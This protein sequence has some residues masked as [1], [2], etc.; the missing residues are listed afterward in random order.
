M[1]VELAFRLSAEKLFNV[2]V[3]ISPS[4]VVN[5]VAAHK[6]WNSQAFTPVHPVLTNIQDF[7]HFVCDDSDFEKLDYEPREKNETFL[8]SGY[9][10]FFACSL[11]EGMVLESV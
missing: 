7:A 2:R 9:F 4:H 1:P 11:N 10:Y 3:N 8:M 5:S 6:M